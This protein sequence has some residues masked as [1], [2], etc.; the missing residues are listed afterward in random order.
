VVIT[1]PNPDKFNGMSVFQNLGAEVIAS[2]RTAENMKGVHDYKKYYF[3]NVAKTFTD[4]TYPALSQVDRTFEGTYDL[5]LK[6]G[7]KISLRELAEPGVST[8]QTIAILPGAL[9]ESQ[10][11]VVGDLIH[12]H[13][14]AW[15]EGGIVAGN[16]VP[17]LSGWIA[18]LKE[19]RSLFKDQPEVTVYGGRG[20]VAK[21]NDAVQEEISYLKKADRLVSR[22]VRGLGTKKAELQGP[23]AQEHYNAIQAE[24]EKAFPNYSLGYMIGYGVYGLVNSKL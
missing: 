23:S 22:Y 15:L 21:L 9:G 14:H 4:Q 24:L 3:V 6:D 19:L 17:T 7:E 5:R 2:T 18:D 13:A 1:H 11:V 10:G 12:F 8:N 20:E 16:P